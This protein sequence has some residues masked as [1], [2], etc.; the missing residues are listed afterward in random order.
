MANGAPHSAGDSA[1]QPADSNQPGSFASL[2]HQANDDAR[3]GD[4]PKDDARDEANR[5]SR[6]A[7]TSGAVAV[8]VIQQPLLPIPGFLSWTGKTNTPA[9]SEHTE[10]TGTADQKA[11]QVDRLAPTT[12]LMQNISA[13]NVVALPQP[14]EMQRTDTPRTAR[15]GAGGVPTAM[16]AVHAT[17]GAEEQDS[18]LSPGVSQ[19]T[20]GSSKNGSDSTA[21]PATP[22][23]GETNAPVSTSPLAFA[24]RLNAQPESAPAQ[25][26]S[27]PSPQAAHPNPAAAT[28][29]ES[30]TVTAIQTAAQAGGSAHTGADPNGGQQQKTEEPALSAQSAAYQRAETTRPDSARA[31]EQA[32]APRAAEP[33]AAEMDPS[34]AE[35]ANNAQVRDVRMQLTGSENQRV[36]VRVLD[37]GGELRVS[38]RADDPSLVRSLQDNMADL[39][40]RL[41]QAHFRSEIWTPRTEAV[42]RSE[43]SSTNGRTLS[44]GNESSGQGGQGKQQNGRQNQQP[45][46]MDDFEETTAGSG[47]GGKR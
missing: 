1:T 19:A 39:S 26:Q 12:L 24:A 31:P 4:D 13:V 20:A 8:P 11:A 16:A 43:S 18:S 29:S 3:S 17:A 34:A 2:L 37:R 15:Q 41:D 35:S 38:V 7:T 22:L 27:P 33:S 40:T 6:P 45:A 28:T 21:L 44:N 9:K 5:N 23:T 42:S 32:A 47:S 46:W 10:D 30:D 25:P 36:D 14:T